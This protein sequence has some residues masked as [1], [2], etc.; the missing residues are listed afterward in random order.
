M[1]SAGRQRRRVE[2][3]DPRPAAR[4]PRRASARSRPGSRPATACCSGGRRARTRGSDPHAASAPRPDR[5]AGADP[6][7]GRRARTCAAMP[8]KVSAR[9]ADAVA[10]P[11]G[12]CVSSCFSLCYDLGEGARRKRAG[13]SPPPPRAWQAGPTPRWSLPNASAMI[14]P[15]IKRLTE[16]NPHTRVAEGATRPETLRR[17]DRELQ[18]RLWRVAATAHRRG[19]GTP[20]L[21]GIRTEGRQAG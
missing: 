15:P 16:E 11:S 4:R 1:R 5:R 3:I 7:R 18:D 21:S 2:A 19:T 12:R 13:L 8:A 14:A 9:A 10:R 6:R 17:K 20:D